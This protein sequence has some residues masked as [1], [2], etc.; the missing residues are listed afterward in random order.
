MAPRFYDTGTE[1]LPRRWLEMVGHT[2]RALGPRVQ[3]SRMVREYVEELYI[4]AARAS[5]AL[6]D[7]E[8]RRPG[9]AGAVRG[10]PG[11][12]RL[13]APGHPGLGRGPDRACGG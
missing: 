12:G 2:L 4:P 6:S 1:G 5:R 9:P 8:R 3:A 10:R 11:A 13:E 7:G